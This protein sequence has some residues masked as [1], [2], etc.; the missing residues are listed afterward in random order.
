M[1]K[2]KPK[3]ARARGSLDW[4][5][6]RLLA[7]ADTEAW[8]KCKRRMLIIGCPNPMIIHR[9]PTSELG[10]QVQVCFRTTFL[11]KSPC[12]LPVR[13]CF[14]NS[15]AG[16]IGGRLTNWACIASLITY[17]KL[18]MSTLTRHST[19][20]ARWHHWLWDMEPTLG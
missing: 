8:K 14:I 16:P 10:P 19:G 3:R 6:S 15:S 5:T 12:R 9:Y 2:C 18:E 7:V 17:H 13:H 4:P 11:R 20:H 1:A